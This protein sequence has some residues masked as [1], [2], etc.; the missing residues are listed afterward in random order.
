MMAIQHNDWDSAASIV[1]R[2]IEQV[3]EE[4]LE[5]YITSALAY[6]QAARIAA[7]RG[8]RELGKKYMG[9]ASR[10]RPLLT[11]AL[12][13]YS[14][15]TLH[16]MASAYIEYAD[17]AGARRL[18][19]EASDIL[20]L[21]PRLG[22]LVEEHNELLDRLAALPAGTVGPSSLTGAELRLLPLL[23]THLTYPE[24]GDRLFVSK[25]TV[26]TQAMSI[27]RKLGVSSRS[28]AVDRAR[29]I[30]LISI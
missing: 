21:R 30:G 10:I 5:T 8:D 22:T 12:P 11:V 4:G 20:A 6:V 18:M 7:H 24:I 1:S 3:E 9:A 16:E 19:R 13:V 15:L 27:Y 23:V 26:K 17:I 14:V 28:E 25:H 29:T 2:A